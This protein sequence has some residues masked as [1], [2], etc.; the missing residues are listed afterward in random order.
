MARKKT[1]ASSEAAGKTTRSGSPKK[2][3]AKGQRTKKA[4]G[5]FSA[6]QMM[7]EVLGAMP[8]EVRK[9]LLESVLGEPPE[10]GWLL[11]KRTPRSR[12]LD[13]VRRLLDEAR[14]QPT[15]RGALPI[16]EQAAAA[17]RKAMGKRFD[18]LAGEMGDDPL[19]E[20]YLE[21]SAEAVQMLL[22]CGD[23]QAAQARAEEL[24]RLDPLDPQGVRHLLLAGHFEAGRDQAASQ[25]LAEK[26]PEAWAAWDFGRVLSSFR[27][28]ERGE[29]AER[30]L[31]AAH[32][33]NPYII[34]LLL[35]ERVPDPLAPLFVEPGEDSEAQ[36][37]VANYL[38]AWRETPGAISWLREAAT[39]Q[40]LEIEPQPAAPPRR[41]P[42]KRELARLPAHSVP[43]W[44]VGMR[45]L[46]EMQLPGED[47]PR[48]QWMLFALALE[49]DFIETDF[50]EGR[51][52]APELW[53]HLMEVMLCDE[54]GGKPARMLVYPESLVG[55]LA[56]KA[57]VAGIAVEAYGDGERLTQYLEQ[58]SI[59]M[60]GGAAVAQ[61]LAADAI[62]AAPLDPD[63]V[64]EA[65]LVRMPQRIQIGGQAI[66]IQTAL[67]MSRTDGMILWHELFTQSP[68]ADALATAVRLAIAM[69]AVGSPRRPRQVVVR[70]PDEAQSLRALADEA[71][72]TCETQPKLKLIDDATAS[73]AE[74]VLGPPPPAVLTQAEG[75]T[76]ADLERFFVAAAEFY[77]RQPW[78]R[79]AMDEVLALDRL[80]PPAARRF[81]LVM[82]QSGLTLGLAIYDQLSDLRAMFS[83][84]SDVDSA[85]GFSVFFCEESD[86]PLADLDAIEQ[87]GWPIAT[88]EAYPLALRILPGRKV[89]TPA[90]KDVRFLTAA[91]EGVTWLAQNRDAKETRIDLPDQSF[92]VTRLGWLDSLSGPMVE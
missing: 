40:E 66:A 64:W 48:S 72:F 41:R 92:K 50:V 55:P 79:F 16:A 18:K 13:E 67:V 85:D 76:A 8:N 25:L 57:T 56:K 5:G 65:A 47:R 37:F 58:I 33:Q 39:R 83:R 68:P 11:Q 22:A 21:A 71:G 14:S 42:S 82:G 70:D 28:G 88:P 49:S 32:R 51:P 26:C 23:N 61:T 38:P 6:L 7:Q 80:Q 24:L 86:V 69:P 91:L 62:S 10:E 74:H 54:R 19:G 73:L 36:E 9:Q 60:Q 84:Q 27:R 81:G 75:I 1:T 90:A 53:D 45:E 12:A 77:R 31:A 78:K 17:A 52:S 87:F 34:S 4:A 59:R 15:T 63:E 43:N 44:I 30:L 89:E 29:V 46:P 35:G 20:A 2:G 3:T